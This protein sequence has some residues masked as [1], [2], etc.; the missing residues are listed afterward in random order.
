MTRSMARTEGKP[1][2]AHIGDEEQLGEAGAGRTAGDRNGDERRPELEEGVDVGD[3]RVLASPSGRGRRSRRRR[4]SQT[5]SHVAGRTGSVRTTS[6]I[7]GTFGR[8]AWERGKRREEGEKGA[9]VSGAVWGDALNLQ[10][11]PRDGQCVAG[12]HGGWP[13]RPMPPL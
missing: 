6:A 12:G 2:G 11:G 3:A 7:A 8:C 1:R 13:P 5:Q 4:C 9:R 10:G